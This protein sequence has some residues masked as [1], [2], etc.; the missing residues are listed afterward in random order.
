MILIIWP[1]ETHILLL[2]SKPAD[3]EW[4]DTINLEK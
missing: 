2:T 4:I 1:G 3:L